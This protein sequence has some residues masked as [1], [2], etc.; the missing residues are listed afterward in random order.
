MPFTASKRQ[1]SDSPYAVLVAVTPADTD[2]AGGVC[3]GIYVG[4][5]GNL[6]I[7]DT[8]GNTVLLTSPA[9]GVFHRIQ[10]R[11]IK[12]ATTATLIVVGY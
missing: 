1:C 8:D 10:A 9:L 7:L 12:A 3:R 6:T 4:G 5:T 2:L 11:Q